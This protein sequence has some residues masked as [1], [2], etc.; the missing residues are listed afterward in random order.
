LMGDEMSEF[1]I[2]RIQ[3]CAGEIGATIK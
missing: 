2:S 3:K 1:D